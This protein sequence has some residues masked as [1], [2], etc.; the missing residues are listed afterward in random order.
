MRNKKKGQ[1][2]LASALPQSAVMQLRRPLGLIAARQ[3][4][5]P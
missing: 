5:V 2:T 1:G 4:E 3:H